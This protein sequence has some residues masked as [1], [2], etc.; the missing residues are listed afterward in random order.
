LT[1]MSYPLSYD[2]L[3]RAIVI[4]A[5]LLVAALPVAAQTPAAVDT[6]TVHQFDIPAMYVPDALAAYSAVTGVVVELAGAVAE[7]RKSAA[8]AG[9]HTAANALRALLAGTDLGVVFESHTRAQVSPSDG[10]VAPMYTLTP[11]TVIGASNRAYA[12]QRSRSGT[13]TD[14]PLRDVPQSI[15]VI[16]RDAIRDQGMLGMADVGRYV[17]GMT[18]GQGEGHRDAPTIRGNSSTADFFADG[19][20]DDAQYFRD[21]YNVERVEVLKG[22]NAL[23]FGRGGAGGVVNRVMKSPQSTSVRSASAGAGSYGYK[24]LSADIGE[25][26]HGESGLLGALAYRMNGMYEN[27]SSFR[28]H[29]E[30]ERYGF[31]PTLRFAAG[32]TTVQAGYEYFSDARIVDRGLPSFKGA[33]LHAPIATFFGNPDSSYGSM[34]VHTATAQ[35]EANVAGVQVRSSTRLSDY[36]KFYENSFAGGA[37][38]STRTRVSLSAYSTATQRRNLLSQLEST[39]RARTGSIDHVLLAGVEV[40][41]QVTSNFRRTGY[42]NDTQTALS[43]TLDAPT[44]ATPVTF[45]QSATDA[46]NSSTVITTA[47]YVQDQLTISSR[48]QAITGLRY[49]RFGID[50]TNRRNAQDLDRSDVMLSPRMGLIFQPAHAAS[51][52]AG[53]SVSHLP[54]A[55]DQFSS[56]TA[57]SK[58]LKPERLT[59]TEFGAKWDVRPNLSLT[60]AVYRLDRSNTSAPDPADATR[61]VQT[62]SQR[63][64]G[65]ELGAAGSITAVWQ[66]I[67]GVAL[68]KAEIT[69]AT[70]TAKRGAEPALVPRNTASLWSRH[71]ILRWLSAGMGVTHQSKMFAAV[72]N[73]VT[74][75]AFQRVDAAL[76]LRLNSALSL[77]ANVENVLD[78]RYFVT[79]HGNNNIMP[80]AP[81][82]VRLMV[83]R[84]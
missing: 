3:S 32:A 1:F 68:Q 15:T 12:V 14:T 52:Y 30:L 37:V 59:N 25:V 19:V 42:Y 79:S 51:L 47:G 16:T 24:R 36:D 57:T 13:K 72:D 29:V 44:V 53:Y 43:V 31:N 10:V 69:S 80:G 62:G 70:S 6:S 66:V 76:F 28:S 26:L 45:R 23:I 46:N 41:R 33:P 81:R 5:L 18:L 56:L 67:G 77:Q 4:S 34:R 11:L 48:W 73:T 8:L 35:I 74:I 75:P 17:P 84:Q 7:G 49:E 39:L 65:I 63:T 60:G 40:G 55:G 64:E 22:P 78:D 61:I 50:F 71:Q 27:S 82:S 58:T 54:G 21:L 20:R 2:R 83:T 38:D 9:R